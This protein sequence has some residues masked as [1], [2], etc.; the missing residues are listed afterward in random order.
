MTEQRQLDNAAPATQ[1]L[2]TLLEGWDPRGVAWWDVRAHGKVHDL[3]D[4]EAERLFHRVAV[5]GIRK[6]PLAFMVYTPRLA[7]KMF[8]APAD[9]IAAWGDTIALH[10][11]LESPPPLLITE[12]GLKWREAMEA[13]HWSLWP[14]LCWVAIAGMVFGVLLPQRILV[15]AMAWV[16]IGYLLSS[17]AVEFFSPRYNAAVVP[18]VAALAVIPLGVVLSLASGKLRD[19]EEAGR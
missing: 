2:L 1:S 12:S 7:W 4:E 5:E 14:V 9:W 19:G 8:L 13:F 16:P 6:D 17:A 3:N 11:H 15:M 10:Q 18:I